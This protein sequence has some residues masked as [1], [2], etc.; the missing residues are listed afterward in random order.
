MQ[1]IVPESKCQ[2]LALSLKLERSPRHVDDK[3]CSAARSHVAVPRSCIE[4]ERRDVAA[5]LPGPR[6]SESCSGFARYRVGTSF[7]DLPAN[8]RCPTRP[9]A[10]WHILS[11]AGD[12]NQ[13]SRVRVWFR[14]TRQA[15]I[16]ARGGRDGES[17]ESDSRRLP[18]GDATSH[19]RQHGAGDRL[20]QEGSGCRGKGTCG[21]P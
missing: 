17:K 12:R 18:Y 7:A 3:T 6:H 13:L 10:R 1:S 11:A 21:R 16:S 8:L 19:F 4:T 14:R 9:G 2:C 15:F 5:K 20:V